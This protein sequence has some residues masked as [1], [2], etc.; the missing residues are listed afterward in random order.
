MK[1]YL[2]IIGDAHGK[3][4]EYVAVA[5]KAKHSIQVGDMSIHGYGWMKSLDNSRHRFFGGNH[6]QYDLI[7]DSPHNLGEYGVYEIPEF[8]PVFW[9]RGG[10][11]LDGK[12]RKARE[13]AWGKTWWEQEELSYAEARKCL[14]LYEQVKPK[15]L[16]SHECPLNIVSW[17]TNPEFVKQFGFTDPIIKTTTNQLLQEMVEIHPPRIHLF[18]HFHK[19]F[20]KMCDP[21]TGNAMPESVED[22]TPYTRFV[23]LPELGYMDF[24]KNYIE[25]L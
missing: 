13:W 1:P 23:C 14:D 9:V 4:S 20:D 24:P 17:L 22:E 18:G 3:H 8:G 6:D 19:A 21:V 2:R 15:M 25:S 7:N 5:D 11:S 12:I 16:L 10:F